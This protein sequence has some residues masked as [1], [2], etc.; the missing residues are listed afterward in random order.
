VKYGIAAQEHTRGSSLNV[1]AAHMFFTNLKRVNAACK[2]EQETFSD[3]LGT[4]MELPRKNRRFSK[5]VQYD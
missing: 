3:Y 5:Q 1:I 4:Y 2:I